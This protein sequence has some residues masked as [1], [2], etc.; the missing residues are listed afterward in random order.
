MLT[1][2]KT[3]KMIQLFLLRMMTAGLTT[4]HDYPTANRGKQIIL[5][6]P[7]CNVFLAQYLDKMYLP[8]NAKTQQRDRY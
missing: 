1:I 5:F 2:I 8:F 3:E 4:M 7:Q 6:R